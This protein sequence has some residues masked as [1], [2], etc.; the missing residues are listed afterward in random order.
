MCVI[1][2]TAKFG[3]A[4]LAVLTL[5]ACATPGEL[6]IARDQ[7]RYGNTADALQTLSE[8]NISGRNELLLYLD[9]GLVAQATGSYTESIEA[10]EKAL[11]IVEKLNYVSVRDQASSLV[12]SDWAARYAGEVSEKLWIHT[13]QMLNFLLLDSPKSAA[14]EARRAVE[15]YEEYGDIL[16]NDIFTRALM[17]LSFESAGQLNS[18]RVEYR[19][20]A[21]DLE[22]PLTTLRDKNTSELVFIVASGFIE[23]KLSGD[24][25]IDYDNRISFPFYAESYQQA[26]EAQVA[27]GDTLVEYSRADTALLDISKRALSERGKRIAVRHALRLAAKHNIADSVEDK[28]EVAGALVR[29]LFVALEQADTRSWETLPAY[30]TLLRVPLEPGKHSVSLDL[31][32]DDLARATVDHQ[33]KFDINIAPGQRIYKL[34]R[35]G[36]A[37]GSNNL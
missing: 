4:C 33:R 35:T 15:L 24:L 8:A 27:L 18:A 19:K 30:L 3:L 1:Y 23:P 9:K 20:L 32:I 5:Q 12:T 11:D 22:A 16:E 6:Q 36:I 25:F 17:A 21:E 10:F 26:P 13:F 14:V 7:F 31:F 34:I 28:D 29:L 2:R 37:T